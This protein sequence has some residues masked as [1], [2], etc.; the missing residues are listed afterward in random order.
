MISAIL[1]NQPENTF[2]CITINTCG[3]NCNTW[4]GSEQV[5]FSDSVPCL[6]PYNDVIWC[7]ELQNKTIKCF[8]ILAF[9]YL[10][11]FKRFNECNESINGTDNEHGNIKRIKNVKDMET[12]QISYNAKKKQLNDFALSNISILSQ[13]LAVPVVLGCPV[14]RM[15]A[16]LNLLGC[17][18][19][20]TY[21]HEFR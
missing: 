16:A 2:K 8:N 9:E 5:D 6:D 13:E 4:T 21:A 19:T 17:L 15:H 12:I 11:F 7:Y 20:L 3:G 1:S 10:Q 18:D 14:T